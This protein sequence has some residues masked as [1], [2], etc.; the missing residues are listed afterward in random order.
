MVFSPHGLDALI[1]LL[2]LGRMK[3]SLETWNQSSCPNPLLKHKPGSFFR[4]PSK[5]IHMPLTVWKVLALSITRHDHLPF[6]VTVT[7]SLPSHFCLTLTCSI[8]KPG[9]CGLESGDW[10]RLDAPT[11]RILAPGQK[12][13]LMGKVQVAASIRHIRQ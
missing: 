5:H 6:T 4:C 11:L 13:R 10:P 12:S 8:T 3:R 9:Y 2:F 1:F 7:D